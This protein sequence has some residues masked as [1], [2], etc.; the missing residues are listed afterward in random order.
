VRIAAYR[1]MTWRER[2]WRDVTTNLAEV[3]EILDAVRSGASSE[4]LA[5]I[6]MPATTRAVFVRRDEQAMFDGMDEP[7]QGPSSQPARR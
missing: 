3:S 1:R 4:A 6:A 7:R 5:T 2:G